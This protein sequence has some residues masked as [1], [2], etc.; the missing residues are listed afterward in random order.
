MSVD[1]I[2]IAL[3]FFCGMSLFLVAPAIW[4]IVLIVEE[5]FDVWK[6]KRR[7]ARKE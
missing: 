7:Q 1:I 6:A 4:M 5:V 2:D 3:I